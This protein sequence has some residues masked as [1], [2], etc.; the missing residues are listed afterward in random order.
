MYKHDLDLNPI[1]EKATDEEL[2]PIVDCLKA[3]MS[4][5]IDTDERYKK[6][7]LNPSKYTDLIANEIRLF[8]GNTF[9]NLCR[10]EG[11]SYKEVVCDVADKLKV[12]YNKYGDIEL[13]EVS[14]LQKV[15]DSA[16]KSMSNE[17]KKALI[18]EI[19][20]INLPIGSSSTMILQ[21]LLKMG[22]FKTYQLAVIVANSIA[23][24]LLGRGLSFAANASL[25]KGLS[26]CIGP[27]GWI[28]SSLW[29]AIDLA[30]PSYRVTIPC[31]IHIAI[32]R[33]K[34]KN[35]T[36]MKDTSASDY[37]PFN[38]MLSTLSSSHNYSSQTSTY[39][40]TAYLPHN[41][42]E[43]HSYLPSS[44]YNRPYFPMT[45]LNT[46][47]YIPSSSYKYNTDL[48]TLRLNRY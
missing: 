46:S 33:Q 34:Q 21:T 9:A 8:G 41:F 7:P 11:V 12:H 42:P 28:V 48:S 25:T 36:D 29:M 23:K 38:S 18:D 27:V 6:A 2:L 43:Y 40:T 1:L 19:G 17:Q 10:G 32:L 30:G 24:C 13:I 45:N 15:F 3:K 26:V 16:W 47:A 31:V 22:G 39:D 37:T 44:R 4:N 20:G 14:I 5:C 35:A